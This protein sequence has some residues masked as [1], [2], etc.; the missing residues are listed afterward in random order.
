MGPGGAEAVKLLLQLAL[1]KQPV[2]DGAEEGPSQLVGE[3][4][5]GD[6]KGLVGL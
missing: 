1:D 2:G 5:V 3:G 4:A 6:E